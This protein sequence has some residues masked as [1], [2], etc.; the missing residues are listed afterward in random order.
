MNP[1]KSIEKNGKNATPSYGIV[2]SQ[3]VKTVSA[4]EARSIDGN[5]KIKGRKRHLVVDTLGNLI[6]VLVHAANLADTKSGCD[7]CSNPPRKNRDGLKHFPVTKV[8]GGARFNL[9]KRRSA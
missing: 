5:K 1:L 3:S 7:M 9:W 2:D 4:S 6:A 8:T